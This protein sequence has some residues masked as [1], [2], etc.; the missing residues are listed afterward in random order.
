MASPLSTLVCKECGYVNEIQRV[1]C[2]NCGVKLDRDLLDAQQ[3]EQ[4]EPPQKRQR[5]I[6]KRMSPEQ[7]S[8]GKFCKKLF[9]TLALAGIAAAVLAAAL[10][11]Q[12]VL[13]K[14]EEA[15]ET[16]QVDAVL[17]NLAAM[18]NG[19]RIAFR[20]A[21]INAYLR[22]EHFK[23]LPTWLT[24]YLPL[25]ALARFDEGSGRLMVQASIAGYPLYVTFSG[26][27]KIDKQAGLVPTC[28]GGSI[29]RFPIAPELAC[30]AGRALPTLFNSLKREQQLLGQLG[31]IEFRKEQVVLG[32]RGPTLPFV[33]NAVPGQGAVH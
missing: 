16:V 2:H 7:G 9:K 19:R 21:D 23:K 15:M 11:P 3:Q 4:A 29:G 33:P 26:K 13:P 8:L 31:S 27:L 17:E 12:G 6:K 18:Q 14:K 5:E 30:A 10:P 1:Y 22:K 28:T 20:E 25:R 32:A 24:E